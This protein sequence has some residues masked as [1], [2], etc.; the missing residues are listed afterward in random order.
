MPIDPEAGQHTAWVMDR[1]GKQ[2]IHQL[3]DIDSIKWE[4]NRDEV[5]TAT[6]HVTAT[7]DSPQARA[8]NDIEP[9]RHEL[10][11][12]RGDDRVWEGPITLTTNKRQG[13]E[14][15]ARDI[16]HY[17]SRT[18]IHAGYDNSYPNITYVVQR[19]LNI[20][21]AELARKEALTPPINVL[22]FVQGFQTL[23][24]AKTSRV[25]LPFQMTL[26][27]H[28]DD[29]A[30]KSGMDYTVIGRK[31]MLWDTSKPAMGYTR[32]MTEADFNG[33]TYVSV[34]GMELAT[35]T[36]V[37]DGQGHAGSAGGIDSYYGEVELLATAYDEE[38]D[39]EVPS[40]AELESQ[41]ERN[42]SM[43]NPTP[44]QVR[45]PDNSSLNMD[46]GISIND[47]VPGVYIPLRATL[48]IREVSQMQKLQSVTVT[49]T[50]DG[51]DVQ[52]VLY[53]ASRPDEEDE[54]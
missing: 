6:V 36:Y 45:V 11:I 5:S 15:N 38:T 12:W 27:E 54:S 8:L 26:F 10:C 43:R 39:E 37:T 42:L 31:L 19:A 2:R 23:T 13:M 18:V 22:P 32:V 30:T 3:T 28:I 24:D 1:G 17:L 33:E 50:A 47:L 53:P 52:I 40:V 41:A 35:R 51:E 25:S 4:R 34:Y 14:I 9:G 48:N 20:I 16:M 49:E 21:N 44:L 29:L 46:G 7:K